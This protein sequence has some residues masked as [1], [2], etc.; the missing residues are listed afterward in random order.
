[1]VKTN[2]GNNYNVIE[3]DDAG[4]A[5]ACGVTDAPDALAACEDPL[6]PSSAVTTEENT[7]CA[8]LVGSNSV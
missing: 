1:M 5:A 8:D 6:T 4:V 7:S 3:P 2:H